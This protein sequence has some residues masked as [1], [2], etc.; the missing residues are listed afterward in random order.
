MDNSVL[1]EEPSPPRERRKRRVYVTRNTEYHCFG[2]RCVAVRSR[3]S[4]QWRLAHAALQRNVSLSVRVDDS[5]GVCPK[6][7]TSAPEVGDLLFFGEEGSDLITT[8]LVAIERPSRAVVASY[9][10]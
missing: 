8:A 7:R 5:G 2:R 6:P 3:S 4:G 1:D 10:V 9:P